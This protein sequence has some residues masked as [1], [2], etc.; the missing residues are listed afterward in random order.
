[1]GEKDR[2][3]RDKIPPNFFSKKKRLV[4]IEKK[5]DIP[6]QSEKCAYI[7]ISEVAPTSGHRTEKL[8]V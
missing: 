8:L 7:P 1:M 4:K 2:Y 3:D 5:I 6:A